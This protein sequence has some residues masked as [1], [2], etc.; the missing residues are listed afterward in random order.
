MVKHPPE[1]CRYKKYTGFLTSTISPA[2]LDDE[3]FGSATFSTPTTRFSGGDSVL[4]KHERDLKNTL[5]KYVR[6]ADN[7]SHPIVTTFYDG[8]EILR[9]LYSR[10]SSLGLNPTIHTRVAYR[11]RASGANFRT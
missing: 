5:D 8:R 4:Q 2:I 10:L 1:G 7:G 3:S 6:V 11:K 9:R